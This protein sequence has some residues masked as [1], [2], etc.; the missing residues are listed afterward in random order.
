MILTSDEL[1]YLKEKYPKDYEVVVGRL[2]DF[3]LEH[4]PKRSKYAN[5]ATLTKENN[6]VN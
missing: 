1:R 5:T 3:I 2:T 6:K 4:D